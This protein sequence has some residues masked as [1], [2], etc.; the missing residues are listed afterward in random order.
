MKFILA[1][2]SIHIIYGD[3]ICQYFTLDAFVPIE[4]LKSVHTCNRNLHSEL[5]VAKD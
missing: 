1:P 3:Q 4:L 5:R 2:H